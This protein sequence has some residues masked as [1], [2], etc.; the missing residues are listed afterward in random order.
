MGFS[1][2]TQAV[3]LSLKRFV[4]KEVVSSLLPLFSVKFTCFKV[5][6]RPYRFSRSFSALVL[7][8]SHTLV[9][10]FSTI[11]P[12][13]P[14][15]KLPVSPLLTAP[16]SFIYPQL[17][18]SF[19]HPLQWLKGGEQGDQEEPS[20]ADLLYSP[21]IHSLQ[22]IMQQMIIHPILRL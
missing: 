21:V 2:E 13:F 3:D 15:Q 9:K 14:S 17:C 8:F 19:H 18:R 7:F 20:T 11:P 10:V 16:S 12:L 22:W 5:P 1:T 4:S 6:P